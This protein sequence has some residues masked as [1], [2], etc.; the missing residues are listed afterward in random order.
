MKTSQV[1]RII[2]LCVIY[3][4]LLS[5]AILPHHHHE[6]VACYTSTHCEEDESHIDY[7]TR[8]AADHHHNHESEEDP[9]RCL[10]I[11][12]YVNS[13]AGI[14]I[15]RVNDYILPEYGHNHL[16]NTCKSCVE[17]NS[18]LQ[19]PDRFFHHSPEKSSYLT[20]ICHEIPLRAPPYF[21][22]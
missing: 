7:Q 21:L 9:Q 15:K 4:S 20:H 5:S 2:F 19:M 10:S 6:E 14:S 22:I 3:L 18:D 11:G 13:D 16:V 17:E 1:I 12:Y 8:E